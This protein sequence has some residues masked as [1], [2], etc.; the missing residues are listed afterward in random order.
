MNKY[1]SK[2]CVYAFLYALVFDLLS[3]AMIHYSELH[4]A[5][6]TAICSTL[7]GGC[8]LFSFRDTLNHKE[9]VPYL[10]LG[11]GVGSFIAVKLAS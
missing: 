7:M 11:Y 4:M 3:I 6:Y 1:Y 8:G 2:Y 5:F 10:L 9:A